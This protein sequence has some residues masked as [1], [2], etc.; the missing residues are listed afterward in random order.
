VEP[1]TP[2][3]VEYRLHFSLNPEAQLKGGRT[4]ATRIGAGGTDVPDYSRR[5]FVL[6]FAG[7][8][9]G[10]L[11]PDSPNV[12]P[13]CNVSGGEIGQPVAHHNRFTG[14]WRLFFEL[15]PESGSAADL[16]CF[17]RRG[18]DVVTETWVYRWLPN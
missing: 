10:G 15:V 2:L 17:L 4:L 3:H 8:A 12:Q 6:D 1:G 7:P 14:G 18:Q 16:R 13:V 11:D 9:V 5:K